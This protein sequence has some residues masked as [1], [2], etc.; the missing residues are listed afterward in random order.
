MIVLTTAGNLL[1]GGSDEGYF[2]A[3]DARNGQLLWKANLGGTVASGPMSYSVDGKQ[4]IAVSAG[5]SLFVY[6]L[7]E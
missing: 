5:S 7:R 6:G 2:F 4:Y 1:F 3:L